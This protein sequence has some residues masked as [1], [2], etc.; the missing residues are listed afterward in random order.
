MDAI[1]LLE[2]QH[3]LVETLFDQACSAKTANA[4]ADLF[5]QIGDAL[6]VH[7]A[8]EEKIFYP[9]VVSSKTNDLLHEA[10]EEHLAAKRLI[11]DLIQLSP[12]DEHYR[13]KLVVLCE[14]IRHHIR[15]CL[16]CRQGL[17]SQGNN[18]RFQPL[19]ASFSRLISCI[20]HVAGVCFSYSFG[21]RCRPLGAF[22]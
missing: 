16:F 6:A 17:F 13:A 15:H 22:R 20:N 1:K 7:A 21:N 5:A 9:A 14:E 18:S 8:I 2:E 4:R 3:E 10:V 19:A 12:N 11:A